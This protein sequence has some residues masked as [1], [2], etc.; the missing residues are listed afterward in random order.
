MFLTGAYDYVNVLERAAD[1]S[2]YRNEVIT[3]NIANAT[4]PG[5][6]RKDVAFEESLAR[7]IEASGAE[8][9]SLT[10]K[11]SNL[12]YDTVRATVYTDRSD[13]SYRLDQNN[14][15][16]STENSELASNQL[17]YEGLIDSINAEF[18]RIKSV[19]K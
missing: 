7:A 9:D 8:S 19:L 14:V 17:V 6:K 12:D 15:D 3:N 18:N 11:V 2:A 13:L 10:K 4:T 5:Y 1:V 16:I